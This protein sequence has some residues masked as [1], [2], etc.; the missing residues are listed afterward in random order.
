M[1]VVSRFAAAAAALT[2]LAGSAAAES[3]TKSRDY[4]LASGDLEHPVTAYQS[5]FKS[6]LETLN[7]SNV[8]DAFILSDGAVAA[9]PRNDT[10]GATAGTLAEFCMRFPHGVLHFVRR[11]ELHQIVNIARAVRLSSASATSCAKI[12]GGE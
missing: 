6:C 11:A 3:C 5:L 9:V 10:I 2:A 4:I 12:V 7:L 8:K 1:R